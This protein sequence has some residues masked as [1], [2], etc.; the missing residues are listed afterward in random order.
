MT[1]MAAH[2]DV[3]LWIVRLSF[4]PRGELPGIDVVE[5]REQRRVGILRRGDGEIDVGRDRL[6][7]G[8]GRLQRPRGLADNLEITCFGVA[9]LAARLGQPGACQRQAAFRLVEVAGVASAFLRLELD[10]VANLYM[11][12][13]VLLGEIDHVPGAQYLQIRDGGAKADGLFRVHQVV[14]GRSDPFL[15][16]SR[17]VDGSE[18]LEQILPNLA[19]EKLAR[20]LLGAAISATLVSGKEV[21]GILVT[22]FTGGID[23]REIF[24]ARLVDILFGR[25]LSGSGLL[26]RRV[27]G[28]GD[29]DGFLKG[30]RRRPVGA[31]DHQCDCHGG[32]RHGPQDHRRSAAVAATKMLVDEMRSRPAAHEGAGNGR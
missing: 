19:A 13:H 22:D 23:G 9:Q 30:C 2:A 14:A 17:S 11:G 24:R 21:V 16:A 15:R 4:R 5:R 20:L 25:P 6:I 26:H 10:V 8:P 7:G 29:G 27:S 28:N 3:E 12:G 31:A 18:P 32:R 1:A